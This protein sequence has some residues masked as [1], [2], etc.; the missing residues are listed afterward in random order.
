[1]SISLV[2]GGAGFIGSHLVEALLAH[3]D[4]VRVFDNF[5]TGN[6]DNLSHVDGKVEIIEGDIRNREQLTEVVQGVSKIFHLAA[7][8]SPAL[9]IEQPQICFDVNVLGTLNLFNAAKNTGIKGIVMASSAAVYGDAETIPLVES[10]STMPLSPYAASKQATEF[11]AEFYTRMFKLPIVSLR[12]FNVYGPRQSPSSEY[13]A[14]IP[15]FIKQMKAGK[16]P[17]IFGDGGQSRDFIYIS[18]V[19]RANLL[20]AESPRAA[21]KVYNVC[22]GESISILKLLNRLTKLFPDAPEHESS[23]PRPG[24]VYHSLGDPTQAK[25]QLDF[26]AKTSLADGLTS[27]VEWMQS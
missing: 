24:D 6:R 2:T 27:I 21:G 11:Y 17:T 9:S 22:T 10:E 23:P 15:I 25:D 12:Y 14:A 18:D 4:K 7:F 26:V 16:A 13:A 5:S 1:M 19:V 3:G 8:V 20:A